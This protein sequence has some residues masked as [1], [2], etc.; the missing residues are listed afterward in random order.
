MGK[1]DSGF[2]TLLRI[3]GRSRPC[4]QEI[5]GTERRTSRR[6]Q[7]ARGVNGC[8]GQGNS[9][10]QPESQEEPSA[11]RGT[12]AA[13]ESGVTFSVAGAHISPGLQQSS[14]DGRLVLLRGPSVA[15]DGKVQSGITIGVRGSQVST[16]S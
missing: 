9:Q 4:P 8:H 14:H 10:R 12:I 7:A 11:S 3:V 13:N 1:E 6:L 16:C 5:H 2:T 15:N